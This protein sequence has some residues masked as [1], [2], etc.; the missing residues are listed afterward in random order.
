[1]GIVGLALVAGVIIGLARGGRLSR[2]AAVRLRL[3][4]LI[5]IGLLVQIALFSTPLAEGVGDAGPPLY[6]LS[7][8]L[9]CLALLANLH[10]P[11]LPLMAVGALANLAAIVANG[12]IMPTSPAAAGAA[13]LSYGEGF[14]N[15][16]VIP[17]P[18]LWPLTDLFAIP[19]G[20]PLANVFSL[21][22]LLIGI[23]LVW[24]IGAAMAG[25]G[26]A[27][28]EDPEVR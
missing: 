25:D 4:P 2:L 19:A 1:V 8:A 28:P 18:A 5:L 16:R 14:S 17:D 26:S 11:G 24:A 27:R 20:L 6:V 12:G 10:L 13:G 21:G 22:D 15:S 23:G 3:A 9:V 7:T